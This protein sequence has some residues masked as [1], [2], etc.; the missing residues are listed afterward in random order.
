[1]KT[2]KTAA[3]LLSALLLAGCGASASVN[4]TC[5]YNDEG[6]IV[7]YTFSAPAEDKEIT[8]LEYHFDLEYEVFKEVTGSV[9]DMSDEEN[10]NNFVDVMQSRLS[11][12][13]D[14]DK[15]RIEVATDDKALHLT[16]KAKGAEEIKEL[17][18]NLADT[19]EI[20]TFSQLKQDLAVEG[21]CE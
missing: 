20:P 10:L 1:M 13:M 16:V 14:I 11:D 5:S 17:L 3:L 7:S 8:S 9:V 2:T 15:E 19:D 12:S 4:T 18:S 21:A 6:A